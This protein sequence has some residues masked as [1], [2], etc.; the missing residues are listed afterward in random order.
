MGIVVILIIKLVMLY[1][2]YSLSNNS[3]LRYFK[4]EIFEEWNW[5]CFNMSFGIGRLNRTVYS[6]FVSKKNNSIY[7]NH[8]KILYIS[9]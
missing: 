6:V 8:F 3:L 5:E 7:C 1:F 4:K 9:T 2:L